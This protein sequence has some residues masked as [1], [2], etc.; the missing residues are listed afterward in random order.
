[1]IGIIYDQK[2]LGSMKYMKQDRYIEAGEVSAQKLW[3]MAEDCLEHSSE[4]RL[5][6]QE[7]NNILRGKAALNAK[8]ALELLGK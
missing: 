1:M 3:A 4:I 7:E 2:V 8:M 6:L 5:K